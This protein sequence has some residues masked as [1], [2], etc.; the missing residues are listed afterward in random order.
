M[1]DRLGACHATRCSPTVGDRPLL[2]AVDDAQ[3]LDDA[4]ALLVHQLAVDRTAFVAL[5]VRSDELV[6]DPVTALWKDE[7]VERIDFAALDRA[8]TS[9][10]LR[11]AL[12]LLGSSSG[13]RARLGQD[14]ARTE[15]SR[16]QEWIA[17]GLP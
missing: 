2:F 16:N 17:W 14:R 11:Q 3:L 5:T 4:S 1:R 12:T 7:L 6:P 15:L 10:L 8:S 13:T 9:S